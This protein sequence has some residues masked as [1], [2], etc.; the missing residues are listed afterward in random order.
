[1]NNVCFESAAIGYVHNIE[2]KVYI[3]KPFFHSYGFCSAA[4]FAPDIAYCAGLRSDCTQRVKN[5]AYQVFGH[6]LLCLVGV[7][8]YPLVEIPAN[9]DEKRRD[10]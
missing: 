3:S 4:H 9:N 5:V 10:V 7:R 8:F 2:Q 1:M 6:S